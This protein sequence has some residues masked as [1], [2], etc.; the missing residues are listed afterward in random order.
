MGARG[1]LPPSEGGMK[2]RQVMGGGPWRR[3]HLA[4]LRWKWCNVERPEALVHVDRCFVLMRW[5]YHIGRVHRRGVWSTAGLVRSG[6]GRQYKHVDGLSNYR[7]SSYPIQLRNP[8]KKGDPMSSLTAAY[9]TATQRRRGRFRGP[10]TARGAVQA[11]AKRF[12]LTS[13]P[14]SSRP[15]GQKR[16]R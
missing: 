6:A 16:G 14:R 8:P 7:E 10:K 3:R 11:E 2:R 15:Q 13:S 9:V 1:G 12:A 5:N 4:G